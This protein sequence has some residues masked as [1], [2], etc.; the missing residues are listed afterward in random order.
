MRHA[1][2]E[3]TGQS[4]VGASSAER[5]PGSLAAHAGLTGAYLGLVSGGL[6]LAQRTGRV[7][8]ERIP[9]VD[10]VLVGVAAHKLSR[11]LTRAKVT[12]FIRAPFTEFEHFAGHGEVEE[13]AKGSGLQKAVGELL[14]CPFCMG[15]WA[16][17]GLTVGYVASPRL[18]RLAAGI[19]VAHTISDFLQLVY[20][21]EEQEVDRGS[22]DAGRT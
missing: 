3:A 13:R 9:L 17:G 5:D 8:P 6:M 16:A 2:L 4:E 18:T 10:L 15:Q 12:N 7:I 21:D 11:L 19:L 1:A 14:L 20:R 22:H